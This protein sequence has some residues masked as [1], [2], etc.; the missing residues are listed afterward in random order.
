[1]AIPLR[2]AFDRYQMDRK[3]RPRFFHLLSNQGLDELREVLVCMRD[4][5]SEIVAMWFGL[6]LE[7]FGDER[8]LTETEFRKVFEPALL[9][10][11]DALLTGHMDAYA[12]S[13]LMTG[14]QLAQRL[15]PLDETIASIQLLNEASRAVLARNPPPSTEV[16]NQL[17]KLG[18]T[19]IIVL[20]AA[21]LGTPSASPAARIT[22]LELE[23][24]TLPAH[25]RTW[26]H[27]LV[28]RT[29]A[30]RELYRRIEAEGQSNA[31]LLLLG[32]PGS[33]KETA[34]HAVHECSSGGPFAALRCD[35]L[36]EHLIENELFGYE[37]Q[38]KN[39]RQTFMGLYGAAEGGTLFLKEICRMPVEVQDKLARTL[40]ARHNIRIV[41]STS[42]DPQAA[43]RTDRLREDFSRL[44][45]GHV[46]SIPP[47]RERRADIALLARHFIDLFNHGTVGGSA[48]AGIDGAAVDLIQ[49]YA[50][51]GNVGQLLDTIESAFAS[52]RS[53]IIGLADLPPAISGING[54]TRRLPTIAFETF[55]DA[56]RAVL[57]RA[58]EITGGNKLRAARLLK[59]SRKKLY[60]GIA[61]YG[62]KPAQ[63]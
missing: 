48:I 39:Q 32:E 19:H 51:P 55:A 40:Q 63:M 24:K 42:C 11:Q 37:R 36:P 16:F 44:F 17:D 50:W 58:L 38:H 59:I 35:V 30:M 20:V 12:A 14:K 61:K 54:Q 43:L 62:L 34:A 6:Y 56:E 15:V 13:V 25:E 22:A 60:S 8:T 41:A 33:G 45:A 23:A 18:H 2:L 7:H 28:G 10:N 31:P 57:Q 1:M 49:R 52:A 26:F 47:L 53:D 9:R 5:R 46:I 21:Y 27:G 29:P 4:H 3:R